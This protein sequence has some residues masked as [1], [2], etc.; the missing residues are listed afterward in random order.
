[1]WTTAW[2]HAYDFGGGLSLT[3]AVAGATKK[4]YFG[5]VNK[6]RLIVTLAKTL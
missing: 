1:M 2:E 3:G 5:D 6:A 4:A